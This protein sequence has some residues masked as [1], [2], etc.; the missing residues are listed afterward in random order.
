[1]DEILNISRFYIKKEYRRKGIGFKVLQRIFVYVKNKK[2]KYLYA[3][4]NK[5]NYGALRFFKRQNF[6]KKCSVLR[7]LGSENM[8]KDCKLVYEL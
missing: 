3:Y 2:F 5:K 6:F 7:Y 4:V 8:L 1:M